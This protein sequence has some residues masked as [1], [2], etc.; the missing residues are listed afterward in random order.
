MMVCGFD[1]SGL[2][3]F[4]DG[5]GLKVFLP[6]SKILDLYADV[7]SYNVHFNE[8]GVLAEN[9]KLEE[10][11]QAVAADVQNYGRRAVQEGILLHAEDNARKILQSRIANRGWNKNFTIDITFTGEG[12]PRAFQPPPKLLK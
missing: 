11:N 12:D 7:S 8:T 5:N 4:P 10:Q 9:I 1:L 3:I 2:K 6:H